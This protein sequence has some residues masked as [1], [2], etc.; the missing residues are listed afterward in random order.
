[1]SYSLL[2]P[3][4]FPFLHSLSSL[5]PCNRPWSTLKSKIS[6]YIPPLFFSCFTTFLSFF[7]LSLQCCLACFAPLF[8]P[9]SSFGSFYQNPYC[10]FHNLS[11]FPSLSLMHIRLP[12]YVPWYFYEAFIHELQ[13]CCSQS[14]PEGAAGGRGG[15]LC[16]EGGG[17]G[18]HSWEPVESQ[19]SWEIGSAI[20]PT[21]HLPTV[22]PSH[23]WIAA[24]YYILPDILTCSWDKPPASASYRLN[25]TSPMNSCL[26]LFAAVVVATADWV[27]LLGQQ[28]EG[29]S[30]WAM[31]LLRD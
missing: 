25:W 28:A 22:P 7:I 8:H 9:I 10:L 4:Y 31:H 11:I 27:E 17:S 20:C 12:S 29:H 24:T 30:R 1:M 18:P 16:W 6:C 19:P 21:P 26:S 2:S 13:K 5:P 15:F 23:L 3:W 14:T